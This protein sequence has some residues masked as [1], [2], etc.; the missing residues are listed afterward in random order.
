[1]KRNYKLWAKLVYNEQEL[2]DKVLISGLKDLVGLSDKFLIETFVNRERRTFEIKSD[3]ELVREIFRLK[4]ISKNNY[5]YW[6]VLADKKT[7]ELDNAISWI[8]KALSLARRSYDVKLSYH[9]KGVDCNIIGSS[10]AVV[11]LDI[12]RVQKRITVDF[13]LGEFKE[14]LKTL[15]KLVKNYIKELIELSTHIGQ[16]VKKYLKPGESAL[17][18]IEKDL[19]V[20]TLTRSTGKEKEIEKVISD[21]LMQNPIIDVLRFLQIY[22]LENLRK[23]ML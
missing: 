7:D 21:T 15:D 14:K 16:S 2:G 6:N 22:T 8:N 1:M 10:D 12:A 4:E 11:F 18:R 13:L 17:F 20:E 9:T 23:I 5:I 3:R 19:T